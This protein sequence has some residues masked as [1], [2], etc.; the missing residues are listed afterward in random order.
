MTE[1]LPAP[2]LAYIRTCS[3]PDDSRRPISG[4][5]TKYVKQ[6]DPK[7]WY[8]GIKHRFLLDAANVSDTFLD[9]FIS[10]LPTNPV[11]YPLWNVQNSDLDLRIFPAHA[12]AAASKRLLQRCETE[13]I[14]AGVSGE[15]DAECNEIMLHPQVRLR[16]RFNDHVSLILVRPGVR[17]ENMLTNPKY[18]VS[19]FANSPFRLQGQYKGFTWRPNSGCSHGN[20]L[21]HF[22]CCG[23]KCKRG[24]WK[25]NPGVEK[26]ISEGAKPPERASKEWSDLTANGIL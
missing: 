6:E 13:S 22:Q 23:G 17:Q 3:E 14:Q 4:L 2:H 20:G 12:A 11:Y 25:M 10:A 21:W 16:Y 19:K 18:D 5:L 24:R 9:I 8:K 1:L 26:L 15:D 7:I